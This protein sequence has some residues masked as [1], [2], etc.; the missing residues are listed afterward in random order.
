MTVKLADSFIASDQT[1][2]FP[3]VSNRGNKYICVFYVYDA[4]YTKGLAIKSGY[5]SELLGAF[6]KVYTWCE[7]G[8]F[9]PKVHRMDNETSSD[10]EDFIKSQN[11]HLQYTPPWRHCALAEKAVQTYK[12]CF[13]LITASLPPYFP[14]SY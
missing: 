9:K 8:G 11:T 5:I 3:R 2:A 13:K 6:T 12:S 1:E 10:V 14:V 4:N 7:A